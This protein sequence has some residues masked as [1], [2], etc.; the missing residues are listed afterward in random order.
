MTF[1]FVPGEDFDVKARY[2]FWD[3]SNTVNWF[4]S[5][6]YTLYRRIRPHISASCPLLPFEPSAKAN[7][8]YA[9]YDAEGSNDNT[10]LRALDETVSF[11]LPYIPISLL[12]APS[13]GQSCVC[14]G[15]TWST[16]GYQAC[17]RCYGR[18]SHP[19]IPPRAEHGHSQRK[20]RDSCPRCTTH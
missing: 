5:H 3:S 9:Y 18:T 2:E 4:K 15:F 7:Y 17:P 14:S 11:L 8:P 13:T 19:A 16:R 1:T 10:R 6:G 20:L 12:S